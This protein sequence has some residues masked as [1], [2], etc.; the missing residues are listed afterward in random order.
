MQTSGAVQSPDGASIGDR[1]SMTEQYIAFHAAERPTSIALINNGREITYAEFARDVRKFTWALRE[2]GLSRGAKVAI[3]C[4]DP[5]FHW[6]LRIG[7]ERLGVVTASLS[8]SVSTR[9]GPV[10]RDFDLVL[11]GKDAPSESARQHHQATP[12]WLARILADADVGAE[13]AAWT[14]SPD[15]PVRMAYTSGTTGTPKRL[16]FSRRNH[17]N[18]IAKSMWFNGFTRRSRNLVCMPFSVAGSYTNATA[19]IRAGGTVVA[20]N[21]MTMEQAIA[22]HAITHATLGPIALKN[23]LDR[24]PKGFSKPTDLKIV[25]WGAALSRLLRDKV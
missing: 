1:R 13:P 3:E 12:Q 21:R 17:E 24:L 19:C 25:T 11:S 5:Y 10:P 16:L 4:A 20:E 18:S 22:S 6:L 7:F 14:R 8:H 15:D 2:F 23:V 9:P